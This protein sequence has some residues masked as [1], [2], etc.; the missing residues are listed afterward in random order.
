MKDVRAVTF[1]CYGTLVDWESGIRAWAAALLAR[2]GA[3][4]AAACTPDDFYRRWEEHQFQLLVP[5]RG[6]RD[7]TARAVER[8]LKDLKLPVDPEDGPSLADAIPTW[9]PFPDTPEALRRLGARFKVGI[10]SNMDNVVLFETISR[11]G[12]P[13]HH[14]TSAEDARAYKPDQAPFELALKRL[15]LDPGE[16]LHAGFGWRYDIAPARALGMQTCFV[17]RGGMPR[18]AGLECDLEVPS[19][20]ALADALLAA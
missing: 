8:V 20:A 1:D 15:A 14:R 6:Y 11:L 9:R 5:Y 16:V 2:K 12:A 3:A 18:P 13:I 7:I 4:A 19:L 17:N 10:V